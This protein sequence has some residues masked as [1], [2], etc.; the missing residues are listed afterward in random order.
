MTMLMAGM[1]NSVLVLESLKN[2]WKIHEIIVLKIKHIRLREKYAE[3]EIPYVAKKGS[4]PIFF[5]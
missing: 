4:G 1:Q 2:G 5:K 3:G